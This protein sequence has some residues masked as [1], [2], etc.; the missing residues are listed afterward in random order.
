MTRTIVRISLL[1][2][3]IVAVG[4]AYYAVSELGL[5]TSETW[6]LLAADLA[7]ITSIFS[8]L[9]SQRILELEEDTREPDV[10]LEFDPYSRYTL[11]QLRVKNRGGSYA[12]NIR[13]NF[14]RPMRREQG[15]EIRFGQE[16]R[17]SFIPILNQ[18][19]SVAQLVG[20][21]LWFFEN[22]ETTTFT[23]KIKFRNAS[24]KKFERDFTVSAEQY[25]TS[26]VHDNEIVKAFRDLQDV[27]AVLKQIRD[28]LD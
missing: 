28:K 20:P 19:E 6:L 18:D 11:T 21:S 26:L 7:V 2:S 17:E 27:P 8:T 3:F 5:D 22:N 13:F 14:D 9:S 16:D 15:G 23:G 24:G 4:V 10:H 12:R 25:R 1:V